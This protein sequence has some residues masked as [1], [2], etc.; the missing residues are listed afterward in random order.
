V[1]GG[2]GLSTRLYERTDELLAGAEALVAGC[3][4]EE[5]CPACVG[6]HG[7]TGGAGRTLALRLLRQVMAPRDSAAAPGV[8]VAGRTG[9]A[10]AA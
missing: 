2:V 7:E 3:D 1:P 8:S 10:A 4:C 6:P 9:A 5:G